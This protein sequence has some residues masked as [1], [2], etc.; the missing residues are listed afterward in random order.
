MR[1]NWLTLGSGGAAFSSSF[2]ESYDKITAE[3]GE[4]VLDEMGKTEISPKTTTI[5]S[6]SYVRAGRRRTRWGARG[7][8]AEQSL[9]MHAWVQSA[10]SFP[11]RTS[12]RTIS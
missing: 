3:I 4:A 12:R 5:V 1:E 9:V 7:P 10:L 6:L 2:S 8:P 11:A